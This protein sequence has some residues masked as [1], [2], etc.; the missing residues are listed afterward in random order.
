SNSDDPKFKF[1]GKCSC[2]TC[3]KS[4]SSEKFGDR[5]GKNI[6]IDWKAVP[7]GLMMSGISQ[8]FAKAFWQINAKKASFNLYLSDPESPERLTPAVMVSSIKGVIRSAMGWLFEKIRLDM[9]FD[10]KPCTSD[11]WREGD[12]PSGRQCPLRLIF[13]GPMPGTGNEN[14]TVRSQRGLIRFSSRSAS[15]NSG[16]YIVRSLHRTDWQNEEGKNDRRYPF[17]RSNNESDGYNDGLNIEA[18]KSDSFLLRTEIEPGPH[19]KPA[20]V[21][22]CLAVDLL[23]AGFFR[24]GRFSTRGLGAVRMQPVTINIGNLIDFIDGN[25]KPIASPP[26]ITGFQLMRNV[27][28]IDLRT[29]DPLGMISQWING[30]IEKNQN[31][32]P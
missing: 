16:S 25:I 19:S 11:Y 1:L 23:G 21:A 7:Q 26:N 12:W 20:L 27:L 15:N 30:I 6:V 17:A 24:L 29:D 4:N 32:K 8:D 10:D 28:P 3:L 18:L 13:G 9:K 22:L 31:R 2:T 5:P 14:E